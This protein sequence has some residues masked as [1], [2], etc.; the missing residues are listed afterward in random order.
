M[1][2]K[3]FYKLIYCMLCLIH[4]CKESSWKHVGLNQRTED[5]KSQTEKF[6]YSCIDRYIL[7]IPTM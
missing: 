2:M 5:A 4:I 1:I 7:M 6:K 3:C